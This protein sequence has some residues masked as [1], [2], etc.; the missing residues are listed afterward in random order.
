MDAAGAR[1]GTGPVLSERQG[2]PGR[3]ETLVYESDWLASRPFFYNVR[4]G[5]AS[6]TIND[7]I[8]LADIEFD[9]EGFNDYLDFG[10]CVF[11][12]TPLRDVRMLRFSSRLLSGPDG[13]RVEYLDDP[14][15]EWLERRST[16]DEVL[17]VASAKIN[18]CAA[19]DGEIVVPTS[20]GF[21]SRL[22]NVLMTDR[23]RVRAFTYGVSDDPASST[24]AVKAAELAQRLGVR[25]DLVPLGSF[26]TYLDDWD[27]LFGVSTHAHGMYQIEF[28]RRI[29]KRVPLS[30]LVLSGT[31]GDRFAGVDRVVRS[32]PTL[33]EPADAY[34]V[35]RYPNMSADSHFST[36]RSEKLGMLRLLETTPRL[37]TEVLPRVFTVTRL[38]MVLLSYLL[39]VPA[40]LGLRSTGPYLDIDLAMRMLTL[41]AELR[42]DR[43]WQR[44]FFARQG[45]DLESEPLHADARNTLN[46]QGM[47]RVPLKPLDVTLLSEVVKP[48]YVRWIN[49]NV[50]RLGLPSEAIWRL[51][52]VRGF[53]RGAK[54]L[55]RT[56]IRQH[57]LLAYNAYL[58]LKPIESLLLRRD[59]ARLGEGPASPTQ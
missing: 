2:V 11:E 38:R 52:Y 23:G 26:H 18:E 22:I 46:F 14:A 35:F 12:R 4:N 13:L 34:V 47:R 48:A 56:G 28:Y 21:D 39:S 10:Y 53:R 36:F 19:G 5:R 15:W 58:T 27:A 7:V 20:G 40:S 57:R 59:R 41:P 54:A 31:C 17:E 32:I 37:R 33:R 8:E 43:R 29:Q 44:E 51:A 6:H 24:E 30:S 49:R 50:G 25:W 1:K 45:V 9:P 16:V 42:R 3:P 55:D